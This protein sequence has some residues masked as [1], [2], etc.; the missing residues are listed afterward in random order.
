[1]NTYSW[2]GTIVPVAGDS[3]T[4]GGV[5]RAAGLP[6]SS[7]SGLLVRILRIKVGPSLATAAGVQVVQLFYRSQ[8]NTGGTAVAQTPTPYDGNDSPA[9]ATLKTWTAA[10]APTGALPVGCEQLGSLASPGVG[11]LINWR[12][13]DTMGLGP[14]V[15]KVP[16]LR[17]Y[18]AG[19]NQPTLGIN[20]SAA[21]A[22]QVCPVEIVWAEQGA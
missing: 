8:A 21:L 13:D 18:A 22:G 12:W 2:S 10:G 6:A 20:F 5:A 19:G 1:M 9:G 11:N 7:T 16:I 14:N 3:V 15:G 4:I 17:H